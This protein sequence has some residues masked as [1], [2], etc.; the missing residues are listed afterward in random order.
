VKVLGARGVGI[1]LLLLVAFVAVNVTE[2]PTHANPSV[3]VL[4]RVDDLPA[5]FAAVPGRLEPTTL[6]GTHIADLSPTLVPRAMT[7]ALFVAAPD[8]GTT[9]SFEQ[10]L[11][12]FRSGD[13][14]P[15][16]VLLAGS[17][18]CP[19]GLVPRPDWMTV[20]GSVKRLAL[21]GVS[22][23]VRAFQ[24]HGRGSG[25][26]LR[27]DD[28]RIDQVII[29]RGDHIGIL[30]YACYGFFYDEGVRNRLIHQFAARLAALP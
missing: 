6:C 4:I 26:G 3:D 17:S 15:F 1:A 16:D 30:T 14:R 19:I 13:A 29:L 28:S 20:N 21:H 22:G 24:L 7:S 2:H 8:D 25:R 10:V 9:A 11:L 5:G 12:S 18:E 23:E 27:R